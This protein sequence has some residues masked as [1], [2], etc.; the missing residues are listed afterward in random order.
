MVI[1]VFDDPLIEI[2][3]GSTYLE[4]TLRVIPLRVE[5]PLVV[6][7]LQVHSVAGHVQLALPFEIHGYYLLEFSKQLQS[8]GRGEGSEATLSTC[9]EDVSI[10]LHQARYGTDQ[11][12]YVRYLGFPESR[13]S[14]VPTEFVESETPGRH[15]ITVSVGPSPILEMDWRSIRQKISSFVDQTSVSTRS[16]WD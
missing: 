10:M 1:N 9:S 14:S 16:P 5:E 7:E 12:V 11:F 13:T 2:R 8:I 3:C 15:L 6:C 4:W